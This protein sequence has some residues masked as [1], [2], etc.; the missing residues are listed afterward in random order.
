MAA[1]LERH[2]PHCPGEHDEG[3]DPGPRGD[4]RGRLGTARREHLAQAAL[5]GVHQDRHASVDDFLLAQADHGDAGTVPYD[6]G[7]LLVPRRPVA[8]GCRTR[9]TCGP[10]V[11][12]LV[13]SSSWP[14]GSKV[15]RGACSSSTKT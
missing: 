15:V 2:I 12:L 14:G 13:S 7:N 8:F 5:V 4:G 9:S 1:I 11:R 10:S 6:E 3:E